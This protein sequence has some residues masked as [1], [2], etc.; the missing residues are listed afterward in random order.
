MSAS[1][2]PP[3]PALDAS[4]PFAKYAAVAATAVRHAFMQRWEVVGRA[5]FYALFLVIFS[6]LWKVA[7]ASDGAWDHGPVEMLWYLAVT[8]WVVLSTPLVHDEV[9]E[10]VRTGDI[11]YLLPRPMSYVGARVAE[12]VGLLLVRMATLAVPG[13][14]LA[15]G[16]S[17][18][19]PSEPRG[20]LLAVPLGVLAGCACVVFQTAIGVAAFWIQDA[21][22]VYWIW[23]KLMFLFGGLILPL[24]V[25][26]EWMRTV[27]ACTP[28]HAL[29]YGPARSALGF[30]PAQAAVTAAWI[31]GWGAVAWW[32]LVS[33]FRRGLRVLDVNGG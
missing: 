16:L 28:F 2:A 18:G 12:G 10:D 22:P 24:D 29:I 33:A 15:W 9:Q 23:Q 19:L 27:A 20:L 8:E 13:F 7:L 14:L 21:A 6:R 32:L 3:A 4:R 25:Y 5:A 17:G 26:P 11:A 30:D 31:V 1:V